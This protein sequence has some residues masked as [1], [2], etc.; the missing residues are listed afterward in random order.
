MASYSVVLF[1]IGGNETY[2]TECDNL[3]SAKAKARE[4][5]GDAWL[6]HAEENPIASHADYG[7]ESIQVIDN[8]GNCVFDILF[9]VPN[10]DGEYYV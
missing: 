9:D 6:Q 2:R 5:S 4:I 7:S 3:K 1:D 10:Q 8:A